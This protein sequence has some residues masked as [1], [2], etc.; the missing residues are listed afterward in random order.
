M[1]TPDVEVVLFDLGGVLIELGG[2]ASLQTMAGIADDEAVWQKWLTSPWVRRFEAGQCSA[3][4]FSGGVVSEWDLPVTPD[5]FLEIFR[6]WP[7]GPLPGSSELL[8][9][10]QRSVPIGCL[11]NT[12]TLHW[13]HQFA[14]WPI[15]GMFDYR[16]LSFDLGLVKPDRSVFKAVADRLPV[17]VDRVLFLDDNALNSDAA[18]S[19]GFLSERVRGV[20]EARQVL[21][22]VGVLPS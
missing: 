11:S 20:E 17:G 16:F 22:D 7:V 21:E 1:S 14:R 6:D 15:L 13:D 18:R 2:V 9:D 3:H 4:E 12:N 19:F 10:V 5:R 8:A